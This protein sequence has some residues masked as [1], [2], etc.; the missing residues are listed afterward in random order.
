V[1]AKGDFEDLRMAFAGPIKN[2][3]HRV[4]GKV[5]PVLDLRSPS[6]TA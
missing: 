2:R 3:R 1:L 6:G 5:V 4:V